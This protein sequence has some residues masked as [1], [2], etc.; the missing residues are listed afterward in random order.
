MPGAKL[1]LAAISP[2]AALNQPLRGVYLFRRVKE[3]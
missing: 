1:S 3:R 2:T